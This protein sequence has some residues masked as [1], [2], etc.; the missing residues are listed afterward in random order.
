MKEEIEENERDDIIAAETRKRQDWVQEFKEQHNGKPPDKIEKYY[1]RKQTEEPGEGGEDGKEE[2]KKEAKGAKKEA[3]KEA[4]GGKKEGKGK[5][6]KGKGEKEKTPV[7][8]VG[9]TEVVQKFEM[10]YEDYENVWAKR[11]E[12]NNYEQMH[13]KEMLRDEIMPKVEKGLRKTIDEMLD[14]ELNNMRALMGAKAKKGKKKKGKKK[15]K[16]SKKAKGPKLPGYKL[17]AKLKG[18]DMLVELV[19]AG[20]VKKMPPSNLTDF[21]GEFNYIASMMD[22]PMD[23]PRPPSMALIRQLVT[24]YIIF[25]LGSDL[26]RKRHPEHTMSFLFYGP[27]GTGKTQIV[28][29]VAT[30]TRAVMFDISPNVLLDIHE[31]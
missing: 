20:I 26:L 16:K 17:I 11:D 6:K 28:Q 13:D 7:D 12:T 29:A 2:E 30:E 9:P 15:K 19:R 31:S 3:K 23:Q 14:L 4:K 25:P 10:Q 24:E 18:K 22:N 1:D 21:L 5:G 27:N 8:E